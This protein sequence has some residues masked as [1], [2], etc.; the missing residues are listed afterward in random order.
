MNIM[1]N[2]VTTGVRDGR[3]MENSLKLDKSAKILQIML[4][5]HANPNNLIVHIQF[6]KRQSA[7]IELYFFSHSLFK[8]NFKYYF[9]V[10]NNNNIWTVKSFPVYVPQP[11]V[12]ESK[13]TIFRDPTASSMADP[14]ECF[15]IICCLVLQG[16]RVHGAP[17]TTPHG[18]TS[19]KTAIFVV[20]GVR[21]K[22]LT[23]N[24][25]AIQDN[26]SGK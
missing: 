12:G 8:M 9:V 20:T 10:Y 2:E 25:W 13:D 23:G 21:I 6:F 3:V 14:Y 7:F 16:K 17:R 26:F 15:G 1:V 22:N 11:S 5:E 4:P 19:Q 24:S 18:V